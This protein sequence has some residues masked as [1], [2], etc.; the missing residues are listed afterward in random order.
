MQR[1]RDETLAAGD[2]GFSATAR[3]QFHTLDGMRGIAALAVVCFHLKSWP[4]FPIFPSAYLAVDLFFA[5]SGFVIASAYDARLARSMSFRQFCLLRVVRLQPLVVLGVALGLLV[6]MLSPETRPTSLVW[7]GVA[8]IGAGLNA[9][10]LP[11]LTG[12]F[13]IDP[14]SWSL[15]YEMLANLGFARFHH[16]LT[17]KRLL[18]LAGICLAGLVAAAIWRGNLDAGLMRKD[19]L[20]AVLRVCFSFSIGVV[21]F[22]S[23]AI[24]AGRVRRITPALMLVGLALAFS[25]PASGTSRV[26]YDLLFVSLI[27]PAFVMFGSQSE[28][29]SPG[30]VTFFA[31]LGMISYPV[32]VLHAPLKHWVEFLFS[33]T[34]SPTALS[35]L[36]L[37]VSVGGAWLAVA[38]YDVPVRRLLGR[39]LERRSS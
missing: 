34:L 17:T 11:N 24:W 28:P 4:P 33:P 26:L 2:P 8:T 32:Y 22:R 19:A 30:A 6:F 20:I 21:L 36:T 29:R 10:M 16:A 15:F 5:L 37:C 12:S 9:F 23:R 39:L 13:L 3:H 25:V 35:A 1:A 18:L 7:A 27:S 14:P 38:R 31:F